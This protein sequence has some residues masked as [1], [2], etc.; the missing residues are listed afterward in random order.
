MM[1]SMKNGTD[2]RH[3]TDCEC[4]INDNGI[5]TV[6]HG[7]INWGFQSDQDSENTEKHS[8]ILDFT[9]VSFIDTVTLNTLTN[10]RD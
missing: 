10:V 5:A 9:T 2:C 1:V 3:E 4:I 8:I 6:T 7:N